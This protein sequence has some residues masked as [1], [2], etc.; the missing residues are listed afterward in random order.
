MAHPIQGVLTVLGRLLLVGIFL[1]SALG[2]KI[3]NFDAVAGAMAAKGIPQPKIMLVGAI[4]FLIA[5]GVSILVGY[6]AR[7]GALLLLI[8]LVLATY[9]FHNFWA[10]SPE[11]VV[12]F[13]GYERPHVEVEMIN[14]MKNAALMGAM[15]M[16]M[17]N[18]SGPWSLDGGGRRA[19]AE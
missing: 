9:Y 19:A 18:G 14:A 2:N 12:Q 7:I 13:P 6:K 3:Q 4:V 1:A 5:G 11:A 17:A 10:L 16:I 8:F 15:L